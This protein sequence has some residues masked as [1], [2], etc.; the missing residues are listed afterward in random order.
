[1][2]SIFEHEAWGRKRWERMRKRARHKEVSFTILWDD[3]VHMRLSTPDCLC[4]GRTLDYGPDDTDARAELDE[5]TPGLGYVQGNTGFLCKHC[6]SRK[7][8]SPLAE[9]QKTLYLNGAQ[10]TSVLPKE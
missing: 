9:Y 10:S 1:M 7:G 6:N 2:P 3:I 5:H 4:C 8:A